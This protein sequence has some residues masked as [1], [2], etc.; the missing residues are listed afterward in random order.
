MGCRIATGLLILATACGAAPP[1]PRPAARPTVVVQASG[2]KPLAPD[3]TGA[4]AV[5]PPDDL[6]PVTRLRAPATAWPALA[7]IVPAVGEAHDMF[8]VAPEALLEVFVGRALAASVDLRQPVDIAQ[9]GERD[10]SGFVVSMALVDLDQARTNLANDFALSRRAGA[11]FLEPRRADANGKL[12]GA[13]ACEIR[14]ARG[15]SPYRLVC[16]P[17]DALPRFGPWLARE[18]AAKPPSAD[19]W[20]GMLDISRASFLNEPAPPGAS[21]AERLGRDLGKDI[22]RNMH[23]FGLG[24]DVS[25]R[26][27]HATLDITASTP[28]SAVQLE[29][30]GQPGK[31]T[32]P[33]PAFFQLPADAGI[34]LY[35]LGTERGP[36]QTAAKPFWHRF[37]QAMEGE[38]DPANAAP[39]EAELGQLF[40]TGGPSIFAYGLDVDRARPTLHHLLE[41][42]QSSVADLSHAMDA[43]QGWAVFELDEPAARWTTGLDNIDRLGKRTTRPASAGGN[44][45]AAGVTPDK[46]KTIT[47]KVAIRPREH[48]PPGSLHLHNS[49]AA[50]PAYTPKSPD[51]APAVPYESDLYVA[52]DG[53]RTWIAWAG[54]S[55]VALEKLHTVLAGKRDRTL[56]GREDLAG[57][58]SLR[59]NMVGFVSLA[60]GS[61]L[62]LSADSRHDVELARYLVDTLWALP[63]RGAAPLPL[64]VTSTADPGGT[65]YELRATFDIPRSS[66]DEIVAL[67]MAASQAP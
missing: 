43:V 20:V 18:L 65:H 42:E 16:G 9:I 39:L 3:P 5:A 35:S 59:G 56:A 2:D 38:I 66:L 30:Q 57:L 64:V 40:F 63:H 36:V 17:R 1:R 27:L 47:V 50:N 6:G 45:A 13:A 12:G 7:R 67:V 44:G 46:T 41:K 26:V 31:A 48:L 25:D 21:P 4:G 15:A 23:R 19:L 34:A 10:N 14:A 8:A 22:F 11:L 52:P 54:R 33:P 28:E 49:T 29:I 32:S 60:A 62:A 53:A 37:V 61:T 24:I 58:A 51:E 55:A